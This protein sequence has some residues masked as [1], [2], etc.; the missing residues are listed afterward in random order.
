MRPPSR[1]LTILDA[2]ALVAATAIGF[3]FTRALWDAL[4]GDYFYKPMSGWTLA[5]TLAKAP[6]SVL[7]LIPLL[8]T[9][10][11]TLVLLRVLQPRPSLRRLP[12][13]PGL[14]ACGAT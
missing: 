10:T 13:Q 11:F 1:R 3:G 2:V 4:R 6:L 5:A 7:V 12:L 8:L 9:W 14:A